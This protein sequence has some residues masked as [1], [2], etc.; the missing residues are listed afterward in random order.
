[1]K[2]IF[3]K[4]KLTWEQLSLIC[5][6]LKCHLLFFSKTLTTWRW[7]QR[8]GKKWRLIYFSWCRNWCSSKSSN[9][10]RWYNWWVIKMFTEFWHIGS[11]FYF[12]SGGFWNSAVLMWIGL[13][14]TTSRE[15]ICGHSLL[16]RFAAISQV[17]FP[18]LFYSEFVDPMPH[19]VYS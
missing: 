11:H 18:T 1:M 17:F 6:L 10:L 19:F 3:S 9:N 5:E 4:L 8:E 12:I 13:C 14:P 2:V 7:E 16:P 15:G